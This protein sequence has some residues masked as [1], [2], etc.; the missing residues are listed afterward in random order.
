MAELKSCAHCGGQAEAFVDIREDDWR[1]PRPHRWYGVECQNCGLS[2]EKESPDWWSDV[3]PPAESDNDLATRAEVYAAWNR[4][5]AELP[6]ARVVE[7]EDA[8]SHSEGQATAEAQMKVE[9]EAERD[10]A[11]A[12]AARLREVVVSLIA[13]WDAE[14]AGPDYAGMSRDTHPEGERIWREWWDRQL[15]LCERTHKLSRSALK[16]EGK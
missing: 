13:W 10:A 16:G 7:L 8:C 4:R 2:L 11:Q 14:E 5:A 1:A 6:E 15:R 12:E 9:A 3:P